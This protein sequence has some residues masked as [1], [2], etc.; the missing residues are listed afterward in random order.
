MQ[1]LR[2]KCSPQEL[3]RNA[4]PDVGEQLDALYKLAAALRAQGI[5]LPD[6]VQQWIESCAE[7]K[8]R[9]PKSE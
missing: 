1:V 9:F 8:Q 7:V 3:R 2:F 4:Y 5:S 6:E